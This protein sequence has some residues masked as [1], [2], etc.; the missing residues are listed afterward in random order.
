MSSD[1]CSSTCI[2]E[3]GFN[4]TGEPSVCTTTCGDAIVGGTEQ[5]DD[6][7]L[8]PNDGCSE[9]CQVVLLDLNVADNTSLGYSDEYFELD[10]VV[11][12]FD[13]NNTNF[14]TFYLSPDGGVSA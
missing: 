2:I 4:C 7:N 11:F 1:G 13:P 8:Q 10:E 3:P 14:S 5:C 6:G 9:T 12:L